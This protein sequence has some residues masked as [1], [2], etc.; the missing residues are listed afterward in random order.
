MQKMSAELR[1]FAPRT[2]SSGVSK[3]QS[4]RKRHA[5]LMEMTIIDEFMSNDLSVKQPYRRIRGLIL[6]PEVYAV[7][8]FL[9]RRNQ[10]G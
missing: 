1:R 4:C 6:V 2:V 9:I 7:S 3:T 8:G 5:T 10:S